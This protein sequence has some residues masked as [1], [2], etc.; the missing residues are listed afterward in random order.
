MMPEMSW[1]TRI[2]AKAATILAEF[3]ASYT[4]V[5]PTPLTAKALAGMIDH[6]ILKADATPA[7]VARLC[8]EAIANDFASVCVNACNVAQCAEALAEQAP[9]VCAVVGFPLGATLSSVKAFEAAKAIGLGA[10][11]I[12]MVINV[13]ALKDDNLSLVRDDIAAVAKACH[14]KGAVLKVIIEAA[15]LT[16][17]EKALACLLIVDAGA[18]YAK[19]STGF[20]TGGAVVRDVALMRAA[21][22]P[23]LGIKAAGGVR[24]YQDAIAMA[25]AG[26]T[27]IGASSGIKIVQGAPS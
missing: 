21:V 15:L 18:D 26:A 11:E 4:P 25:S 22:G 1:E 2:C 5:E 3:A 19:T 20:S 8:D 27:R 13:G 10:S 24:S 23:G 9:V 17:E 14:G 12:D 6:T 16:D 7:Q